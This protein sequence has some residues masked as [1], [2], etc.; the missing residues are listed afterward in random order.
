MGNTTGPEIVAALPPAYYQSDDVVGLAR[1]LI[2]RALCSFIDRKLVCGMIT[3]TEA[4]AGIE[5]KASH[6]YGGR[7]TSRTRV[8][9]RE[10]GC[11]YIYLC[12]GVHSLFNVVTAGSGTPHAVLIRSVLL[13]EG[14]PFAL[15]R[16]E[17]KAYSP[18]LTIGPGRLSK[19]MGFHYSQSGYSLQGPHIY[20]KDAKPIIPPDLI[21]VSSR[22]GVEYAGE[23]AVLPYR[24]F[25][26]HSVFSG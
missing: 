25:V 19:A 23:D 9:F 1:D 16:L 12:Y 2:G 22:I 4:Y 13:T 7:R 5:D 14:I 8:M 18:A 20:I 24:F 10:G 11:A 6:A 26:D 15:N 21:Q 17:K 3:E